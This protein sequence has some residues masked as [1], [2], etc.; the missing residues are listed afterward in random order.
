M[1]INLDNIFDLI[2]INYYLTKIIIYI[3]IY[4]KEYCN[5][6]SI[7][8]VL[9]NAFDEREY[10]LDDAILDL[11]GFVRTGMTGTDLKVVADV[12]KNYLSLKGINIEVTNNFEL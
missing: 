8:D 6:E 7:N 10:Y 2:H 11:D 4:A 3:K 5:Y 9:G 1:K 12:F